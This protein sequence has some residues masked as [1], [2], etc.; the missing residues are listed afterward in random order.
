MKERLVLIYGNNKVLIEEEQARYES[1]LLAGRDS[2]LGVQSFNMQE[3][4]KSSQ[5]GNQ[6]EQFLLT[7]QT[8]PFLI[9]CQIFILSHLEA[10]KAHK[11]LI[12]KLAGILESITKSSDTWVILT[13]QMNKE[14]DLPAA[15]L[16]LIKASGKVHK[17]VTYDDATPD[18]WCMNRAKK[19][20]LILP[21]P[22]ALLLISLAGNQLARL[23]SELEKL[24]LLL[25]QG[26]TV[27]QG[28]LLENIRGGTEFSIFRITQSLSERKLTPA[29]E[30]L[31]QVLGQSPNEHALLFTLIARQFRKLT[32]I[33]C[34]LQC[35]TAESD[36]LKSLGLHPFLG[37]RMIAQARLF[38]HKELFFTINQLAKMDIPLKFHAVHAKQRLQH[39]FEHICKY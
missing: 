17:F 1:H 3:L 18:Q 20:G 13:A 7:L 11:D 36:I 14:Q 30:T 16:K 10:I 25:P 27:T 15:L 39:L 37:K 9:D 34:A 33:A 35:H 12:S 5:E 32:Q 24:S 19:L 26:A 4:L 2:G 38:S 31:D 29:L 22:S 6:I 21:K 23:G 28:T 8:P